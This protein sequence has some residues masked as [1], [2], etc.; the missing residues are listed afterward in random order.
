M[1]CKVDDGD[2]PFLFD[3]LCNFNAIELTGQRDVHEDEVRFL[4]VNLLQCACT[5]YGDGK[6]FV[7]V[8]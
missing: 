4:V 5:V 3:A 2:V 6:N 8:L 1:T 7:S